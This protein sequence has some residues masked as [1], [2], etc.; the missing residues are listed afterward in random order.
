MQSE[1]RRA[2]AGGGFVL[3]ADVAGQGQHTKLAAAYSSMLC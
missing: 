3:E 2:E 1:C